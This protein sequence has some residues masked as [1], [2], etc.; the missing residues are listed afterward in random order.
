MAC[1]RNGFWHEIWWRKP[2]VL[3]WIEQ[4]FSWDFF[5]YFVHWGKYFQRA[6]PGLILSHSSPVFI[7]RNYFQFANLSANFL[8]PDKIYHQTTFWLVLHYYGLCTGISIKWELALGHWIIIICTIL[9]PKLGRILLK[10]TDCMVEWS[11]LSMNSNII[12]I[13]GEESNN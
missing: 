7:L 1:V 8:K 10:D 13:M 3:V 12:Q 6:P 9:D 2:K 5:H 11:R 4:Y